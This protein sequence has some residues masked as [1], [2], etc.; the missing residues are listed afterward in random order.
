MNKKIGY[1]HQGE[2][3]AQFDGVCFACKTDE[4]L[5]MAHR[6]A[7]ANCGHNLPDNLMI[8]CRRCNN[9][10]GT[11]SDVEAYGKIGAEI[12]LLRKAITP[13]KTEIAVALFTHASRI[14]STCEFDGRPIPDSVKR[15]LGS[16]LHT[17]GES[18]AC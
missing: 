1:A 7:F 15:Y 5:E 6:D 12:I 2:I 11:K 17:L 10:R 14:I 3:L 13:T 8:E 9:A 4:N 18:L 16:K